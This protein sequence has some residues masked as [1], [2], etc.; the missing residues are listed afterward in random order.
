MLRC[1]GAERAPSGV[2]V[3]FDEGVSGVV[4][5]GLEVLRLR[6]VCGDALVAVQ[7]RG[8]VAYDV[9]DEL[10]VVIST[11]SHVLLVGALE[12]AVQ[13]ARGLALGNLDELLYPHMAAQLR[14]DRDM[15]A[16]IVCAVV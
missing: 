13:L 16:L 2:L 10:R 7:P 5:D 1:D 15:R 14:L 11:L 3:A 6:H 4:V 12:N 8:D 9:L